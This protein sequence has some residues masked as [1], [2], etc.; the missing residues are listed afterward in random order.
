MLDDKSENPTR[1]EL[2]SMVRK[3]SKLIGK[4]TLDEEEK[5][6]VEMDPEFWR[7][8]IDYFLV[9]SDV[10]AFIC[11]EFSG[12][13][14]HRKCGRQLSLLCTQLDELLGDNSVDVDWR[15]SF[16][17]NLIAHT[18]FSV[19]VAICSHQV[20]QQY[21][22]AQGRPLSP[23]YKV[24]KTVYAS[25]SRVNF[26]LDS[27]KEVETVPAYP[28]ICF[29]VDDFDSTFDAV[30]LTDTDHCYC[31][32]LNAHDGAAFPS[33]NMEQSCDSGISSSET[34]ANAG[35]KKN[36]KVT[37]FS[38]FVNYQMVREA[39]DAGRTGFGSLLSLGHSS[40][41]TDRIY[42]KG[43]GG[44]GEVEVAV[45]G[46]LDQ[47]KI[48]SGPHSPVQISKKGLGIGDMV[49]T[50]ASV[51]SMAAKHAYAA[52]SAN[53]PSEEEMLP[54]KCCL[55][56][57]SLP[58]E[59]IAQDLLFKLAAKRCRLKMEKICVAVRV[60]PSSSEESGNV[61]QWKVE[62]NC[63]SLH[64]VNNTPIS[65]MSFAFDHVFDQ[66]CSNG[67]V[68]ELLIKN[69]IHAAVEGFN[70]TAFA[71][72][73]TSSG[74][75]FTMNGTEKDPGIIHRAVKDIFANIQQTSDREFLIRVSYMEIY[76]EDIID[77]FAVE[78]QKLQIHESLERG[79]FVAGL[80]EEI[81]N[82][83]DQ[84]LSLMQLGE[85]NRHF[86]DTNMNARSSRSHTI[87]RM[88]IESNQK[89]TNSSRGTSSDDAIRVSVLNLVDLAGSERVAKTQAGGVRLKE[90]K[91]I[92]KSLMALGNV[93]NKLSEDGKQRCHIPYRDSKLTRILQPALGGNA[94]TSIICTVAPEQAHIEE[95]KGTLQFASRAKRITNCVQVNEILTDAALLKRQKLEIEELRKKLQGSH[96]EVLEQEI[97][98][99]RNEMLKYE[100]ER[101][102]LATALEEERRSHKDRDQCIREEYMKTDN[103]SNLVS[104]P[105]SDRSS[106][107]N[108]VTICLQDGRMDSHSMSQE[109]GF[110]TPCYKAAP[111]VFVAKRSQYW[112][113]NEFSPLPDSC[114]NFADEDTWMKMN[115]GCIVDLDMLHMTPARKVQSLP[116]SEDLSTENYSQEIQDLRRHLNLVVEERDEFKR[117]YA[118]QV[119]FNNQLTREVSE[120]QQE[121][122]YIREFPQHLCEIV[123]NC[124]NVYK[125]VFSM[126]QEFVL[127]ERSAAGQI[128]STTSEFGLCLLSNLEFQL[129]S[130]DGKGPSPTSSIQE[131]C[132]MLSKRL[133]S[134]ISKL[135][136][137]DASTLNDE[138]TTGSLISTKVK[139]STLGGQI[140]YWKEAI[141]NEV[142]T[143]K[144]NYGDLENERDIC[145]KLL[146]ISEGKYQSL[147]REFHLLKEDKEVLL[148]R[149]LSLS[150]MLELVTGQ[151]DN[152][153]QDLRTELRRR[154]NLEEEVK[155][156]SIA[157][158]GRQ[159]S[160]NS[161]HSDFK[162]IIDTMKT[163][164]SKSR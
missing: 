151:K 28:D 77:L 43:P 114:I 140:A 51:A 42:M 122:L 54:L 104:F 138:H 107:Q 101:E 97:L 103:L 152:A 11:E 8:I 63:V 21:Q 18:S 99:L 164:L 50:A 94:K 156:F 108:D 75:T 149:I 89:D 127:D 163:S 9:E 55:M 86:G 60:R 118:E 56:S 40:V 158:A 70:G 133:T 161:F 32:L 38:G 79:V 23:I 95:T 162:A 78:T 52:A 31:V 25:P 142:A 116:S 13:E 37:L 48:E 22:S 100:L 98:K 14:S 72:G 148:Q 74:K 113:Q 82:N 80:R 112:T 102:K 45:S 105:Y 10:N 12:T 33:E 129:T 150:Q 69:I 147:E 124:K 59:L 66:D 26:L 121:F 119:S 35:K 30:V 135:V 155:L 130:M 81:V 34:V 143:I 73:Q 136:L 90:G 84:V 144:Q 4:T 137:P 128:L 91:H 15:R 88:V 154:K 157:F 145:N 67:T 125:D 16:Y 6:D 19:T 57:I 96:A 120:L 62:N 58:W 111:N 39:Y 44:R 17:L 76:N 87:F 160:L 110:S 27:R 36:S 1:R 64:G 153:F 61:F 46:V 5:S 65:G 134:T 71:Y 141:E 49:R 123:A 47:S 68:Y 83:V 20:L 29:A 92:N 132:S 53:R 131:Q 24:V 7:G 139:L 106:F 85:A 3:H 126:L 159:R 117:K 93:I 146:D 41:K 109:N 2:L 115:K